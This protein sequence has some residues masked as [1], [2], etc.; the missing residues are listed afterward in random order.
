MS[1]QPEDMQAVK[2]E[3]CYYFE[4]WNLPDY[5]GFCRRR[6]PRVE[7][8]TRVDLTTNVKGSPT[9]ESLLARVNVDDWCGDGYPRNKVKF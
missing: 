8:V 2:C 5:D 6:A 1:N 4:R 7:L 3:G 9:V